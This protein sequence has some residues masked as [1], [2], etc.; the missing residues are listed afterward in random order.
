MKQDLSLALTEE[1][2]YNPVPLSE[3]YSLCIAYY[4]LLIIHHSPFL[5]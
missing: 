5:Q 4:S 2:L 1:W 3:H